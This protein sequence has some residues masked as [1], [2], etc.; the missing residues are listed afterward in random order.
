[1]NTAEIYKHLVARI[2]AE[3]PDIVYIDWYNQ[4]LFHLEN[5]GDEL[6]F[7]RPAAFIEFVEPKSSVLGRRLQWN[8]LDFKVHIILDNLMEA[9]S[10]EAEANQ[11]EALSLYALAASVV[12]ALV[13]YNT[14]YF[15]SIGNTGQTPDHDFDAIQGVAISFRTTAY[16]TTDQ[17]ET[18]AADADIKVIQG[19]CY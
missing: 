14:A 2:T 7:E 18:E 4:Q 13:G 15:G 3:V 9:S 10:L 12:N 16:D 8:E 5:D 6:P 11:D 17:P 19:R 1:M